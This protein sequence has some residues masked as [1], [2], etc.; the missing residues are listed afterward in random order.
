MHIR[1]DKEGVYE[2]VLAGGA[3]V[4]HGFTS[5]TSAHNLGAELAKESGE[6]WECVDNSYSV[7]YEEV[8]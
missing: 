4:I 6:A 7:P 8:K 1:R 3:I 5:Y 2:V